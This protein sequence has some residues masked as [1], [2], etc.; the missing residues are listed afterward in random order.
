LVINSQDIISQGQTYHVTD[1]IHF[2]GRPL[3]Y[4]CKHMHMTRAHT[5]THTQLYQMSSTGIQSH[6]RRRSSR[7]NLKP[8]TFILTVRVVVLLV[9]TDCF[10]WLESWGGWHL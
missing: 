2:T 1:T 8:F 5:H 7:P 9:V 6:H 4:A 10:I 3:A